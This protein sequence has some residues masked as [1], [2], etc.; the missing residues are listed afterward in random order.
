M[1][2]KEAIRQGLRNLI[3]Q[4]LKTTPL[5]SSKVCE[6]INVSAGPTDGLMICDC[7]PID[8]TSIIEDVR[9]CAEYTEASVGAGLIL[10]PKLNSTVIV[11]FMNDSS[12]FVSM[13]SEVDAIYLNGNEFGGLVKINV[14]LTK[15]NTMELL[16]NAIGV[17]A[18]TVTPPLTLPQIVPTTL[19]ELEN[20][21]VAH[22]GGNIV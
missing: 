3:L 10:V 22:G 13:V 8:G 17:W 4:V 7:K 2:E 9:L 6:V 18:L 16:L 11:S 1:E 5:R 12:A 14:L 20:T 21:K 19:P 15:I